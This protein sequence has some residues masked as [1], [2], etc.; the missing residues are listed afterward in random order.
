MRPNVYA[1]VGFLATT[2]DLAVKVSLYVLRVS[3]AK[4]YG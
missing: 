4:I 1:V 2:F 3:T